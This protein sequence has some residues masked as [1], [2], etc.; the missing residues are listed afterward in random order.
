MIAFIYPFGTFNKK[1]KANESSD[2]YH[3]QKLI[4]T[5]AL[6]IPCI[7]NFA[8]ALQVSQGKEVQRFKRWNV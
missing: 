4:R 2:F 6:S 7:R 8:A 5:S 1:F 3:K